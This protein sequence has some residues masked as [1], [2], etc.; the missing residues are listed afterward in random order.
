MS[1]RTCQM[2][3]NLAQMTAQRSS[4]CRL[5]DSSSLAKSLF[6]LNRNLTAGVHGDDGENN[7]DRVHRSHSEEG[8]REARRGGDLDLLPTPLRSPDLDWLRRQRWW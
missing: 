3:H 7:G 4:P 5:S 1:Q 6:R 2:T 8:G